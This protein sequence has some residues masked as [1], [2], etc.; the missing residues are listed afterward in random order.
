MRQVPAA[1][2]AADDRALERSVRARL[3]ATTKPVGSLGELEDLAVRLAVAL[4]TDRPRLRDAQV[5]V[6]AADHGL[7][8]HGVSAYPPEVTRQMVAGFL[9]GG[10]A[11][12]VLARQHGL[13]LTV[14][15][16]G[17]VEPPD[18]D[19]RLVSRRAGAGTRDCTTGPAMTQ[20]TARAA[21]GDGRE[22]LRSLP[23][24]A[25]LLGEMGI[26]NTSSATLVTSL[27]LDLP[28]PALLGPGTGLDGAGLAR[29]RAVLERARALHRGA[30]DP[31]D[32]LARV[33][34]FEIATLVGVVLQCVE[35]RRVVVVDGF[36][37]AAA[38]LVAEQLAPGTVTACVAAHRSAEPGHAVVLEALG[39]APLLRLGLRLGEA[40]GAAL[41]W[42]LLVSA[43][44]V[45]EE[46]ATFDSAGVS[47][48]AAGRRPR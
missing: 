37:T 46:M 47:G 21:I 34:G 12:S 35:Q 19:P 13:G 41:A 32:V 25:V 17:T 1:V 11:I 28:V 36:I 16:C 9:A 15:D 33:G 43:C 22:V 14:V 29:K 44:A 2:P 31:L 6:C 48:P 8:R 20:E 26:A 39:L 40:S 45:L 38:V 3:A 42:P 5:V 24:N 7:A 30:R 27:L 18:A 23:G 4:G 10:A